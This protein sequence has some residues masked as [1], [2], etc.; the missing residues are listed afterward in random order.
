MDN[1]CI[2]AQLRTFML[3]MNVFFVFSTVPLYLQS[4]APWQTWDDG[5]ALVIRRYTLCTCDQ[6][7]QW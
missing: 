6:Q 7:P 2:A 5:H 1:G 4:V 3:I